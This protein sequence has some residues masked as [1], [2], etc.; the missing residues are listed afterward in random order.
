MV[1]WKNQFD[2][3]SAWR[4]RNEKQNTWRSEKKNANVDGAIDQEGEEDDEKN[5]LK[6]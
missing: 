5:C 4:Q 1:Q 2:A 6:L 3:D